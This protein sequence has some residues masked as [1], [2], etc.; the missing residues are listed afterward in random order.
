MVKKNKDLIIKI[1]VSEV[2]KKI[3]GLFKKKEK[4]K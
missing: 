4:K 2:L 1:V 3:F